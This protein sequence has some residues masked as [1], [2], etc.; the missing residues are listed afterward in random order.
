M[1]LKH[2]FFV[3][4]MVLGSIIAEIKPSG[5]EVPDEYITQTLNYTKVS[6]CSVELTVNF[7]RASFDYKRLVY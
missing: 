3:D 6:G 2:K 4:V 5:K 7:G 1:I